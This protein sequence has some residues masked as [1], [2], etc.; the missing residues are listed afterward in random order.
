MKT[1]IEQ[2]LIQ[3]KKED[4]FRILRTTTPLAYGYAKRNKQELIDFSS[5]DYLALS[6]H[7]KLITSAIEATMHFGVGSRGSR[8]MTG[9]LNSTLQLEEKIACWKGSERALLLGSG[10]MANVGLLRALAIDRH[11]IF[12]GDKL[13]HASLNL[14]CQASD[15]K[16][17]AHN[18]MHHLEQLLI[19]LDKT[20][21]PIIVSDTV[22]SMDGDIAP[23]DDLRTLAQKYGALLYL[24]DAHASGIVG[25]NGRGY[26][27]ANDFEM[28]MGTCSKALGSYGAYVS[29]SQLFYDFFTNFCGSF[30]FTTALPPSIYA[31]INAAIDLIQ[32]NEGA[33]LRKHLDEIS[34][35]AREKLSALGLN[36]GHCQSPIIPIILG[37]NAKA[38]QVAE[39]LLKKGLL[40]TA[41]RPPTVP[42]YTARLRLS[43]CAAHSFEDI[44]RLVEALKKEDLG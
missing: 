9:T 19:K 11:V 38:V 20:Q 18:D 43:L 25:E 5:N 6:M 14:G 10:Y 31:S 3:L 24:D 1:K 40:V 26:A 13:N 27:H 28:A 33:R 34:H 12:L 37:D 8:L 30:I 42:V 2:L 29:C 35:I 23:C 7:D 32:S 17:Y 4:R 39:N 16:R 21:K 15:F 44:D 41:I 22:F 36:I